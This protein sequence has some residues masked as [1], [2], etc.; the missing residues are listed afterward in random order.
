MIFGQLFCLRPGCRGRGPPASRPAG[1][2]RSAARTR[3]AGCLP[4]TAATAVPAPRAAPGPARPRARR[5]TLVDLPQPAA[6]RLV[7]RRGPDLLEQL[8]DHAADPHHL[9]GLLDE[10]G[11]VAL[12]AAVAVARG[13]RFSGGGRAPG[14]RGW[15]AP[16]AGTVTG[17]PSGPMPATCSDYRRRHGFRGTDGVDVWVAGPAR[18]C[19]A[20]YGICTG[21]A[22]LGTNTT[23]HVASRKRPRAKNPGRENG[24]LTHM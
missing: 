6:A 5:S 2:A 8:L 19:D 16:S 12:A 10:V 1:P 18:P 15:S 14:P 24:G 22:R 13:R 11:E 4:R 3:S 21:C 9:G 20:G 17:R 7:E 23:S